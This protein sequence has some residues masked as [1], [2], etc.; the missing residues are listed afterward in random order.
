M[1]KVSVVNNVTGRSYGATFETQERADA[2]VALCV[3]K[4]TWGK[5]GEYTIAWKDS[6]KDPALF[7]EVA[8]RNRA[9]AYP[10]LSE[11]ADAY[12]HAQNGN[13]KPLA[14]YVVACLEVKRKVPKV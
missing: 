3:S 10:A 4:H 5:P 8:R 1:I 6:M 7:N 2:W 11:F 14:D 12:V 9:N 13:P